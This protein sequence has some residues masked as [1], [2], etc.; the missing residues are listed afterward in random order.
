MGPPRFQGLGFLLGQDLSFASGVNADGSVVVGAGFISAGG[1]SGEQAFRWTPS[2][3]LTDL[4]PADTVHN[5]EAA[6]G[7][8]GDGSVVVGRETHMPLFFRSGSTIQAARWTPSTGWVDLGFLPGGSNSRAAAVNADGSVVVG[9]SDS[10]A[11][12]FDAFRWTASSGMV[13]LGFLPG[14]DGSYATGVSADGSVVVGES[15]TNGGGNGIQAY[16][17]TAAG[18]VGLGFLPGENVS[19]ANGVSADG[20]VVVGTGRGNTDPDQAFR[21]TASTGMVALGFLPGRNYSQAFGANADGSVVV[22][23]GGTIG[24]STNSQAFL[25]DQVFGMQDLQQVLVSEY[26]LDLAG[27][28]TLHGSG[29]V[30]N[31]ETVSADGSTI[32]GTGTDP[33]GNMQ[34]YVASGLLVNRLVSG[35]Y[36]VAPGVSDAIGTLGGSGTVRICTGGSLSIAGNNTSS[37]PVNFPNSVFSGRITGA[38]R[39]IKAGAGTA[40]LSGTSDYAGG[41]TIGAGTLELASGASAGSG[42]IGFAGTRCTLR[43]DATSMPANVISGFAP[44]DTIDLRAVSFDSGGTAQ[45]QFGNVLQIVENGNIYDL[46]LDPSANYSATAFSLQN[47]GFGDTKLVVSEFASKFIGIGDVNGDGKSDIVWTGTSNGSAV[48]WV[49]N[50][51]TT[52]TKSTV[53]NAAM[54]AEWSGFGVGDFNN[55]GNSD[56]L[57]TNNNGQVAIW[58]LN[59]PNLAGFGIPAGQ[60]GAEW[61]VAAIADFNGDHKS[62]LLWLSTNHQAA[63]WTMDGT[64]FAAFGISNGAMGAEW[65]V[66]GTGDFNGD[67]RSDVLW[68]S[69]TGNIDIWEMNGASLS[70]FVQNVGAMGAEWHVGGTGHFNGDTTSD[71][72]WVDTANHVQIWQMNNGQI[73]HIFALSGLDGMEWHLQGVGKFANDGNSDLLWISNSGALHAWTVN[74]TQVVEI[75]IPVPAGFATPSPHGGPLAANDP[76]QIASMSPGTDLRPLG[77][78]TFGA[79]GLTASMMNH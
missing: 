37:D 67:G 33:G 57:W 44:T 74:G 24:Q 46:Q 38:G 34:A 21:W 59:G 22:G 68:E 78:P 23:Y 31:T 30:A 9:E 47:D 32:V 61:Y 15:F 52:F 1:G 75:P 76:T 64:A 2:T 63:V 35:T 65:N 17:W 56:L 48:V 50:N 58:D 8:N 29:P 16:R 77:G 4:P 54:G 7:V 6:L 13:R 43:I 60:M 72:V 79:G 51:Y 14:Y 3:G 10:S 62:D 25:W 39:V 45:L 28:S 19:I 12:P 66:V 11:G 20:F 36:T 71:I 49:N 27:W 69:N 40:I 42:Q 18:M 41:T 70:G 5:A 55:D 26:G 73:A 53:P